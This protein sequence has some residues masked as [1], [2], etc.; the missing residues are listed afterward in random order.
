LGF[1]SLTP[2]YAD[3]P[4]RKNRGFVSSLVISFII[5]AFAVFM[6]V[7]SINKLRAPVVEDSVPFCHAHASLLIPE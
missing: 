4:P 2:T 6:L 5:V 1:A 3:L 7:K